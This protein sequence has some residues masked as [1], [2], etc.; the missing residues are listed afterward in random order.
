MGLDNEDPHH[1]K[2]VASVSPTN[3][4]NIK[5]IW[6][7]YLKK[8]AL[9]IS[10]KLAWACLEAMTFLLLKS[11]TKIIKIIRVKFQQLGHFFTGT[12]FFWLCNF[13]HI[14]HCPSTSN[15]ISEDPM[16]V[17]WEIEDKTSTEGLHLVHFRL[18]K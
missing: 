18:Y 9:S 1:E 12:R 16:T 5:S 10:V 13:L 17:F 15:Q 2:K 14:Y 7:T 11:V 6:C 3:I 4:C 8:M